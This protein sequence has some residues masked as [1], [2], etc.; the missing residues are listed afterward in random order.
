MVCPACHGPARRGLCRHCVAS[1]RPAR[2]ML[3]PGGILL[4]AAYEHDGAARALMHHLKYR[5]IAGFA[6]MAAAELSDLVPPVPL[7]PV[8]R[9]LTRRL[10]YG[11]DPARVIADAL[12]RRLRV[13]VIDV[14]APRIHSPRRAGRTHSRAVPTF[15]L[16]QAPPGEVAIVDD[17]VTTGGTA[18]AAVAAVGPE[19]VR[20]VVA[21]NHANLRDS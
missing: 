7:V 5:G 10:K 11:V 6:E 16:R 4:I 15:R 2:Q 21:A 12:S 9:A 14:L 19:K 3:L 1:L 20:V 8:P 13:P 18:L 17:V